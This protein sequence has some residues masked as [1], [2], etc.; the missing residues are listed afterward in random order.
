[1]AKRTVLVHDR[2]FRKTYECQRYINALLHVNVKIINGLLIER[3]RVSERG[4]AYRS[5]Y[6]YILSHYADIDRPL[7]RC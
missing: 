3:M 6:V 4:R 5:K 7:V 2:F 1:M